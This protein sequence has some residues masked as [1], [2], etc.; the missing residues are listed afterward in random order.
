MQKGILIFPV[1]NSLLG[2]NYNWSD[3]KVSIDAFVPSANGTEAVFL[4]ARV[5]KGGCNT[6]SARG[7]FLWM[8]PGAG[9]LVFKHSV[10]TTANLE[11]L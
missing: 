5:N 11:C 1:Y 8:Y 7:I 10:N 3:V 9:L 2:G 4:A 6:N